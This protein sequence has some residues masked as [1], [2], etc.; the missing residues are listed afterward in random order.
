MIINF[1]QK[2]RFMKIKTIIIILVIVL[3][4]FFLL[5]Y[6]FTSRESEHQVGKSSIDL[7]KKESSFETNSQDYADNSEQSRLDPIEEEILN[8]DDTI[9]IDG[10]L[11]AHNY[12]SLLYSEAHEQ[13]YWV[14]YL[15]SKDMLDNPMVKRKD[16]F[17]SDPNVSTGSAELVDYVGSGFDRGHLCPAK[18]MESSSVGMSES[19]F[20]SNMSPQHPS[21]NR[22]RWKQLESQVRK[23]SIEKDSLIIFCGGVMDSIIEFIGPNEVA[24]PKYYYKTIYSVKENKGIAFIMPNQKCALSLMQYAVSIDSVE[25]LTHIDFYDE[26]SLELQEEFEAEIILKSWVP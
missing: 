24:V 23:W 8:T 22:G 10:E 16:N 20:M 18:D 11:V 4:L 3:T 14:K 13:A 5:I 25:K 12:Y 2:L 7:P 15:L 21:L 19:F 9:F 17:R 6:V 1:L 26:Y